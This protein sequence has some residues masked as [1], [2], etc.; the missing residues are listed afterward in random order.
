MKNKNKNKNSFIEIYFAAAIGFFSFYK[1]KNLNNSITIF[2]IVILF[3]LIIR[4]IIK[5]Y[6]KQTKYRILIASGINIV[7]KIK[8]EEFLLVHF[9]NLGYKG[10]TTAKTGDYGVDLILTKD[11]EKIVVQAK[12][13]IKKVGIEAVQQIIGARAYYKA[14]K[15]IVISNNYFTQNAAN[16]AKSSDVH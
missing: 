12:R 13:W 8:G 10:H 15:C 3:S 9:N 11:N 1:Y 4:V 5:Y 7:D 2:I 6:K 14:S 16:L